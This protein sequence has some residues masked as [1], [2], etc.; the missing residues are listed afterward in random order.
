MSSLDLCPGGF[1]ALTVLFPANWSLLIGPCSLQARSCPL[2][3]LTGCHI[4]QRRA[5]LCLC[6]VQAVDFPSVDSGLHACRLAL[7][8]PVLQMYKGYC[9]SISCT[10]VHSLSNLNCSF[11]PLSEHLHHPLQLSPAG[12]H[13]SPLLPPSRNPET[14]TM[15]YKLVERFSVCRCLYFQHAVDPCEAFGQRGHT[16]QEKTVLVGY[17]CSRHGTVKRCPGI[18]GVGG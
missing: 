11:I 5:A 2:G 17:A 6:L 10:L 18:K 16:V 9:C 4:S 8:R 14:R 1:R 13:C 15:C 12:H 7:Q 3:Y